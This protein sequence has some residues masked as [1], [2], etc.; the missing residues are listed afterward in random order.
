M[1]QLERESERCLQADDSIRRMRE[2]FRALAVKLRDRM[3]RTEVG[4]ELRYPLG[5]RMVRSMVAGDHVDSAVANPREQI[6][7]VAV[8]P[9]RRIHLRVGSPDHRRT[10]VEGKMMRR[11]FAGDLRA[12]PARGAN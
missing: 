4:A 12:M 3:S 8:I 9:Q 6:F 11:H 2:F 10:F 5:I 7:E 1:H